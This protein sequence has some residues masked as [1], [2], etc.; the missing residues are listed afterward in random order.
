[1]DVEEIKKQVIEIIRRRLGDKV[2]IYL[3]GSW[4]KGDAE[5]TSDLDIGILGERKVEETVFYQIKREVDI[6]PTLRKIDV[7][8]LQETGEKFKAHILSYAALL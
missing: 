5:E 8:D 3:Y 7:V 4:A 1:M 2:K 6:I